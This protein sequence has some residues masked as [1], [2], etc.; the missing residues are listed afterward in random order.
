MPKKYPEKF[1]SATI[2]S[3]VA[4]ETN[5][6]K[7]E[8]KFVLDS[9]FDCVERGIKKGN[10]VPMG[11][12]GKIYAKIRPARKAIKGINPLTGQEIEIA[13]RKAEAVPKFTFG[14]AFKELIAKV[15]PS[16]LK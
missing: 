2:T 11:N 4:D 5:L 1:T 9:F 10:R 3:F 13:A 14:K 16:V 15:K 12:L 8:V 7:K 6:S